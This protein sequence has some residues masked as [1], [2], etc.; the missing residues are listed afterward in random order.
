MP[1]SDESRTLTRNAAI[2]LCA[3]MATG[4]LVSFSMTGKIPADP[5]MMLAS[6]LN[7]ILG[8]LWMVAVAW[9]LPLTRLGEVGRRRLALA[10]TV[11]NTSNWLITLIKAFLKVSG[12]DFI[13]EAANDA[14]FVALTLFVVLPSFAA[15]GA[16]AW[17]L[18]NI[19]QQADPAR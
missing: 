3:G 19:R 2:L 1:L 11:A 7:A 14:V 5:H 8:C 4:A 12:V 6:H 9:S 18:S 13:G 16:W 17:S 15:A 10:V